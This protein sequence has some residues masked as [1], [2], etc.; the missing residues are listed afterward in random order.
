MPG[1]AGTRPVLRRKTACGAALRRIFL[2]AFLYSCGLVS[3]SD[4][5]NL[6]RASAG[7]SFRSGRS[8]YAWTARRQSLIEHGTVAPKVSRGGE[9]PIGNTRHPNW[10][11]AS[12]FRKSRSPFASSLG[13][14]PFVFLGAQIRWVYQQVT[15][16]AGFSTTLVQLGGLEPPTS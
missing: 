5:P 9:R 8:R 1:R 2:G 11:S 6:I 16:V 13:L 12:S 7:G 10:R 3:Y 15:E 14:R 4:G